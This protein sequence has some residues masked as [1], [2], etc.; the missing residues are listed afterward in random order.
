MCGQH[1]T[2]KCGRNEEENGG[3][4]TKPKSRIPGLQVAH[5]CLCAGLRGLVRVD[6]DPQLGVLRG[7]PLPVVDGG[8]C[9]RLAAPVGTAVER[10]LLGGGRRCRLWSE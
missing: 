9:E 2:E 5:K 10:A 4:K 7:G 6:S 1:S 8:V 3:F